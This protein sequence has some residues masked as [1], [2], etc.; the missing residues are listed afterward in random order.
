M[1]TNEFTFRPD[2]T[3]AREVNTLYLPS[4]TDEVC[5]YPCMVLRISKSGKCIS[6]KFSERYYSAYSFGLY[7]TDRSVYDNSHI[8]HFEY[9][10]LTT[11][12]VSTI[13]SRDLKLAGSYLKDSI[14]RTQLSGG[15]KA[16]SILDKE[17]GIISARAIERISSHFSLKTGDLIFIEMSA[18]LFSSRVD[19]IIQ[20]LINPDKKDSE[21][22]NQEL[23]LDFFIR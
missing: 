21:E 15:D 23:L 10:R 8:T 20:T 17:S 19:R 22:E 4:G 6:A 14:L 9:N 1:H 12:D 16:E 2:T 13:V 11:F 18:P 5:I 3:L 7:I